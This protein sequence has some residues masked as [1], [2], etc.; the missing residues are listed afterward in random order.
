MLLRNTQ[1]SCIANCH[2]LFCCLHLYC[3]LFKAVFICKTMCICCFVIVA[4]GCIKCYL[5]LHSV[6]IETPAVS[7][8]RAVNKC[9][10]GK[11]CLSTEPRGNTTRVSIAALKCEW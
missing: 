9:G 1:V 2:I 10:L 6:V 4:S 7:K 11:G 3:N 8:S 5:F